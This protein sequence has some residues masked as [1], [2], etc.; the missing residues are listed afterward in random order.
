MP[1][2]IGDAA[3]VLGREF[4]SL[5]GLLSR[6]EEAGPALAELKHF[7]RLFTQGLQCGSLSTAPRVG[8]AGTRAGGSSPQHPNTDLCLSNSRAVSPGG[9]GATLPE[10]HLHRR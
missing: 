4:Y 10:P 9:D 2:S 8:R 3:L 5:G 7:A 6:Q 1:F